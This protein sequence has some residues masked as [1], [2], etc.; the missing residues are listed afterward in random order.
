M[1]S[2]ADQFAGAMEAGCTP[3]GEGL[4]W[5]RTVSGSDPR[6]TLRRLTRRLQVDAPLRGS[7]PNVDAV[8]LLDLQDLAPPQVL[9]RLEVLQQKER[10]EY[11]KSHSRQG[12]PRGP[13][14]TTLQRP[15]RNSG[16]PA[17]RREPTTAR[18]SPRNRREMTVVKPLYQDLFSRFD[19]GTL[20]RCNGGCLHP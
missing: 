19:T 11:R 8:I 1:P 12:S 10:E 15:R 3:G 20:S 18:L 6:T 16:P 4:Q 13:P 17:M 2:Q 7:V 5:R 9:T 14:P